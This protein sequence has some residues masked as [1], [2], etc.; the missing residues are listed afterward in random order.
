MLK[1][2]AVLSPKFLGRIMP[3]IGK[4]KPAL[5]FVDQSWGA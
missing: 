5:K 2:R 1:G 3:E 4:K